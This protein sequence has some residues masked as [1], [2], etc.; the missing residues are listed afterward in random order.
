MSRFRQIDGEGSSNQP[1]FP[2]APRYLAYPDNLV[3]L[4]IVY[5]RRFMASC[6][7]SNSLTLTSDYGNGLLLASIMNKHYWVPSLFFRPCPGVEVNVTN[8]Q[9]I[10]V[11]ADQ[12][13]GDFSSIHYKVSHDVVELGCINPIPPYLNGFVLRTGQDFDF[14]SIFTKSNIKLG[15]RLVMS[16]DPNY[17]VNAMIFEYL[18]PILSHLSLFSFYPTN[19]SRISLSY[20]NSFR[21][22]S[23]RLRSGI[24]IAPPSPTAGFISLKVKKPVAV[25]DRVMIQLYCSYLIDPIPSGKVFH[26]CTT[27]GNKSKSGFF[28]AITNSVFEVGAHWQI[29]NDFVIKGSL[30]FSDG[31]VGAKVLLTDVNQRSDRRFNGILR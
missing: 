3:P 13:C 16:E 27:L 5:R 24:L 20:A 6:R 17:S 28:G 26:I 21:F 2:Y 9:G 4:E 8:T 23:G 19:A 18:H 31:N 12:S 1:L 14:E 7:L 30:F 15:C 22:H 11:T 25:F 29:H 10:T